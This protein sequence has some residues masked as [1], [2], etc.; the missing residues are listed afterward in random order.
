MNYPFKD[1]E[2]VLR[3]QNEVRDDESK[4]MEWR[5]TLSLPGATETRSTPYGEREI[6]RE[7]DS[8]KELIL[9]DLT[10]D[11]FRVFSIFSSG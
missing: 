11:D 9:P 8:G 7:R 1:N 2:K 3:Q 6:E 10:E 5:Q 4:R